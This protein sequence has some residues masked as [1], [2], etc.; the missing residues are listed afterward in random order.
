MICEPCK[1][2]THTGEG[3]W[4]R[5]TQDLYG[6]FSTQPLPLVVPRCP[7]DTWCDCQHQKV[8]VIRAGM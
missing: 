8:V 2:G 5:T 1:I 7:G 3:E 6:D 4:G